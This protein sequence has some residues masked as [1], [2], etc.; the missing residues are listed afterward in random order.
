MKRS[1]NEDSLTYYGKSIKDYVEERSLTFR[2]KSSLT[3]D[4]TRRNQI[5]ISSFT[6][7]NE[8]LKCL[9]CPYVN[10]LQLIFL[11][12]DLHDDLPQIW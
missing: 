9:K 11:D 5:S 3:M 4:R 12:K 2:Y 8:S 6:I 7:E 10:C 1:L